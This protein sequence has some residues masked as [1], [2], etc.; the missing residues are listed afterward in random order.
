MEKIFFETESFKNQF[1]NF[2]FDKVLQ[3]HTTP[4]FLYSGEALEA[5][6]EFIKNCITWKDVSV[7]YAMKANY[8]PD[9]LTLLMRA[10]CGIDAVSPAEVFLALRC[11]FAPDKIIFTSNNSTSDEIDE[12]HA[13]G[14]LINIDSLSRLEKFGIA[15]PGS[16]VCL[17]FNCDVVAGEHPHIMT[18]GTKTKFGILL[19]DKAR[20]LEIC[21]RCNLTVVGVHNHTGSGIAD[22]AKLI[23]SM[24]NLLAIVTPKDFPDLEFA[25]FGGGFK[26]PYHPDEKEVDYNSLGSAMGEIF[27]EFCASFGRELRLYIEPGKFITSDCG[28]FI[29]Q[30]NT[31]K[32]NRGRLIA[33][34]N[35]G[36]P[37]LIRPILYHAYHHIVNLSN[38]AGKQKVYDICGNICESGDCFAVDREIAEIR[39]GDYLAIMNAGAYCHAMASVY[40]LRPLPAEVFCYKGKMSGSRALSNRELADSIFDRHK[41][42]A[43]TFQNI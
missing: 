34:V 33:G 38:P 39:E 15:H 10:G 20:A 23:E 2:D 36:F 22:K 1:N 19:S 17:R 13:T 7:F 28:L 31:L 11:G 9:I 24:K 27:A 29:V 30:V 25:D 41:G 6:Y 14:V 40:N 18:G 4:F 3:Q 5:R 21:S 26:V 43:F 42:S 35:S 32:D 16:D 8:N 12:V 37:H